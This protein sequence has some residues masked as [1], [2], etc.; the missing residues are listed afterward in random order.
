MD[1]V[2][3]ARIAKALADPQRLALMERIAAQPEVGCQALLKACP[4]SQATV[5]HHVRELAEAG[6]VVVR[7]EG[8]FAYF[9][10]VP[11]EVES[12]LAELGRRLSPRSGQ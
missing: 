7:R 11:E 6:L 3:F 9:R 4:V 5:S 12:Y 10:A 8:K 1:G 2:R